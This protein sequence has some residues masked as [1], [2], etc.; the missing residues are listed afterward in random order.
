MTCETDL[1]VI[2][3]GPAGLSAAINGSS[4]GLRVRVLDSGHT[5]GGQ[6]KESSAIENYPGFPEGI[7]GADLMSSFVRQAHKFN[8]SMLCPIGA[9]RVWR[10]DDRVH[11]MTED[12]QEH[13]ARAALL[14]IGLS[15][16]RLPAKGIGPLMGRGVFYG[17]PP[18]RWSPTKSC[19]VM[20]VG[21]ANSAGQAVLKLASNQ[22]ASVRL[23]I[24]KTI[25]RQ[26]STYLIDRIRAMEN[27]EVCENCEVVEQILDEYK[28]DDE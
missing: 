18:G 3:G 11:V 16:R 25:D 20:V 15:Y 9:A 19:Q 10:E 6:A 14:S 23:V 26:M 4:E 17:M 27:V 7:T 22:R 5:L 28:E 24:R 21:G 1:L 8:T 13:V 2:G 12:Y